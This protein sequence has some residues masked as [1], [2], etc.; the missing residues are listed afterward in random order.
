MNRVKK[1]KPNASPNWAKALFA[2]SSTTAIIKYDFRI[3][4]LRF[5][6]ATLRET[7]WPAPPSHRPQT[8]PGRAGATEAYAFSTGIARFSWGRRLP[9]SA[10]CGASGRI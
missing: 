5:I 4:T 7:D 10:A 8:I 1:L 6:C 2:A 3:R 9:V